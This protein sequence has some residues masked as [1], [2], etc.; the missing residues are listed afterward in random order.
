MIWFNTNYNRYVVGAT[1]PDQN[2]EHYGSATVSGWG[3]LKSNGPSPDTLY[4]VNVPIVT[5]SG[6]VYLW[7]KY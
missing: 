7:K 4:A 1:L 2:Q 5:D 3:S 6:N